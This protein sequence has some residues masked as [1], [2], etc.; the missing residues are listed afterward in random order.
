M[1][2]MHAEQLS[3]SSRSPECPCRKGEKKEKNRK[4]KLVD[5]SINAIFF[6]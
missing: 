5:K 1:A 3:W 2:H 6:L 4:R